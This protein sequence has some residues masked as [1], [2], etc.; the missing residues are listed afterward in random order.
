MTSLPLAQ[1]PTDS[2]MP[3]LVPAAISVAYV[4]LALITLLVAKTVKDI[5]TP[6]K[7]DDELTKADNPALGLTVAGYYIGVFIVF[8]GACIGDGAI[9][10][11]FLDDEEGLAEGS[12]LMTAL[13]QIG[14]DLMWVGLGIVFLNIGRVVLDRLVLHSFSTTKEIITDRNLGT[15]AVEFAAYIAT[16]L[17]AAGSLHGESG[18]TSHGLVSA[19]VFFALGQAGLVLFGIVY[20]W[21]TRYDVHEEIEKDNVAAGVAMAGNLVAV[22]VVM[23]RATVGDLTDW[24]ANLIAFGYALVAGLVLISLLRRLTDFVLMPG[25]TLRHEIAVDRNVAAAYLEGSV[26]VGTAAVVFFMI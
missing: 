12:L 18:D 9:E 5:A 4:L 10:Q 14:S 26:A 17:V 7:L 16:G 13:L 8:L 2:S 15:G 20:Q 23:L 3:E 1:A 24:S 22:G 6:Y 21:A 11:W 19:L 25:T